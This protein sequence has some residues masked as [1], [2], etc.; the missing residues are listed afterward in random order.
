MNFKEAM[1]NQRKGNKKHLD[2]LRELEPLFPIAQE[3]ADMVSPI[4]KYGDGMKYATVHPNWLSKHTLDLNIYL[5]EK[6]TIK[7]LLPIVDRIIKDKRLDYTDPLPP[8]MVDA[9]YISCVFKIA[10]QKTYHPQLDVYIRADNSQAC[11]R[12]GTGKYKEIMTYECTDDM[13]YSLGDTN[14]DNQ[15]A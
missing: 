12:I 5:G 7:D 1:T 4:H 9:D 2:Q 15:Q 13:N 10:G 6:D 14:E 3:Y 11:K 8:T